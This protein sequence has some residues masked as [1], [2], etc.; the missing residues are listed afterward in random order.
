M[1]VLGA[2]ALGMLIGTRIREE[3]E[4]KKAQQSQQAWPQALIHIPDQYILTSQA[5]LAANIRLYSP[6]FTFG[7]GKA[8]SNKE[9]MQ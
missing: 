7:S 4:R 6:R 3:R 1:G 2:S 8:F 9:V 5:P